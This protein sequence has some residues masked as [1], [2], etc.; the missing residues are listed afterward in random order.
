MKTIQLTTRDFFTFK[1]LATFIYQYAYNKLTNTID[2]TANE[3]E[4]NDLGY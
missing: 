1:S 3:I 4:L 2:V